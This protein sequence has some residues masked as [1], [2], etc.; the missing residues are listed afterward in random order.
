MFNIFEQYW[1]LLI[2][3]VVAWRI[4]DAFLSDRRSWWQWL[5]LIFLLVASYA[6]DRLTETGTITSVLARIII[7]LAFAFLLGF[8]LALAIRAREPHWHLWLLPPCLAVA[9]FGCDWLVR[10]DLEKVNA[11]IERAVKAAEQED[12]DTIDTVIADDYSDSYHNTK[13]PLMRY[14]RTLLSRP[15][16]QNNR[17][18]G[19]EI[20]L[21]PPQATAVLVVFSTFE[22]DSFVSQTYKPT[23]L[24]KMELT[25]RKQPDKSWLISRAEVLE[26][27]RRPVN[28]TQIR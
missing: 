12:C 1:T 2:A 14:C 18:W 13:E 26:I 8:P 20:Q 19:L 3:A 15:L 5:L 6:T 16:V 17:T 21:S 23:L 22:P 4:L 11:L 7:V 24:T 27:D 25:L 10:T 9:A 28:W